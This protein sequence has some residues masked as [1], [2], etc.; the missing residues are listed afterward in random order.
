MV[1]VPDLDAAVGFYER[2]FGLTVNWRDEGSVGMRLPG[3]DTEVVLNR[4]EITGVHYLVD[5]VPSVVRAA[6]E[7]GCTVVIAPFDIVIGKCAVIEDPF[8]NRVQLLDMTKG[9]RTQ[10][11]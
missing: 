7:G 4:D 10:D 6:V 11:T 9:A 5:D 1:P 2:V 3:S 8:G